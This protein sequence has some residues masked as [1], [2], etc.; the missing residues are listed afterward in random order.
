MIVT[1]VHPVYKTG[2]K[3]RR[4]GYN[5]TLKH[6]TN[7]DVTIDRNVTYVRYDR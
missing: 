6:I 5:K 2:Y 1:Y 4:E 7:H 3:F